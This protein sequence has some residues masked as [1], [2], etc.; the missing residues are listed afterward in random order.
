MG[1]VYRAEDVRRGR[2]DASKFLPDRLRTDRQALEHFQRE[3][4]APGSK[5]LMLEK[6]PDAGTQIADALERRRICLSV[7]S[8]T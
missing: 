1:V 2:A 7:A 5:P 4:R 8:L 6:L 3:A